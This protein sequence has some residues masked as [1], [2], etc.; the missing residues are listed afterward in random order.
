MTKLFCIL[1]LTPA[2]LPKIRKLRINTD[3]MLIFNQSVS[4][5]YLN[6]FNCGLMTA[7]ELDSIRLTGLN[8]MLNYQ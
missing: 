8:E 3:D 6:L 1:A 5:E 4:Q 7:E 2:Y